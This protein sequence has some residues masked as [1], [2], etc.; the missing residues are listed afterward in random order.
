M[1]HALPLLLPL[2]VQSAEATDP[3]TA[4]D[5]DAYRLEWVVV[6]DDRRL[7]GRVVVEARATVGALSRVTLDM[8][9]QLEL[10][11]ARGADGAALAS[12]RDG[13]LLTVDLPAPLES[14]EAFAIA[15]DYR[16]HP[17]ATDSFS[18]FH[19]AQTADG[20]P[21]INTSCQGLGAHYWWPCKASYFHP[22]DKPERITASVTVPKGL[23]GVSNGR[24][25]E[26]VG[27]APAWFASEDEDAAWTTWRYAHGYPLETYSVTL[28]AAPYEVVETTLETAAGAVPFVYYVLPENAEKAAVQFAQVPGLIAAFEEAFGPWPFPGSK[29]GLVETNFWGMEHSTAVAYGSS[30]PAWCAENDAPDPYARRNADFD[31][32]LVHEMAH[33]WWGNAVSAASWGDFWVHEGLGTYAEGAYLEL[34]ESRER[35]DEY[36]AGQNRRASAAKGAL[37]RGDGVDSGQAYASLIYSKGACVLNTLRHMIDDDETWWSFLREFQA[38]FRYGNATTQDFFDLLQEMTGGRSYGWFS[39]QYV[40]GEGSPRLTVTVT[41][42]ERL[43]K[44]RIDNTV[45]DFDCP[46]DIA[47]TEGDQERSDRVWVRGGHEGGA[48]YVLG[49]PATDVRVLHLDRLIGRH[50]VTIEGVRE[51]AAEDGSGD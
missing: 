18:G 46:V 30:Y 40:H 38:R 1:L 48:D 6:P 32:I 44:L 8:H 16:G 39:R 37:Y 15:L 31:Y 20:S 33:E 17:K 9:E 34:T 23:V 49:A 11:A 3:R 41:V 13:H 24:F 26:E 25:V 10:V 51:G 29:I 4:Y 43:L 14:G 5:V 2:F 36:F 27:G 28:N 42:E 19:W 45:G 35:A 47:W 7:E 22:E 12:A 50:E 21:W